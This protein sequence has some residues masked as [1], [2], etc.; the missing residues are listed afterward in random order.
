MYKTLHAFSS[1]YNFTMVHY[2]L[3]IMVHWGGAFFELIV[4]K[5]FVFCI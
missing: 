4:K 2:A 5:I 1:I 3:C